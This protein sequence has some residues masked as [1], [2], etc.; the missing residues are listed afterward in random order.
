MAEAKIRAAM[1]QRMVPMAARVQTVLTM[2]GMDGSDGGEESYS[3]VAKLT[4][5]DAEAGDTF[6]E[7]LALSGDNAVVWAN[8]F[9]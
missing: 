8:T 9:F 7:S 5:S 3:Q 1:A 2:V 6:G 4:A